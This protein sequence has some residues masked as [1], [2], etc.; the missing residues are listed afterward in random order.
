M[1]GETA[2]WLKLDESDEGVGG[3]EPQSTGLAEGL[4][5]GTGESVGRNKRQQRELLSFWHE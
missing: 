5:G 4:N 2:G 1:L 3:C